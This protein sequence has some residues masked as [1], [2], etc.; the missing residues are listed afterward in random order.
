[1]ALFVSMLLSF[2]TYLHSH[3]YHVPYP[4]LTMVLSKILPVATFVYLQLPS[5]MSFQVCCLDI[6]GDGSMLM[7]GSEDR[8]ITVW[9]IPAGTLM[10]KIQTDFIP[11]QAHLIENTHG[12]YILVKVRE[13]SPKVVLLKLLT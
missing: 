9:Q 7:C 2:P 11:L 10:S 1:M 4:Q 8:S 13:V 5:L 6:A 12:V 3:M